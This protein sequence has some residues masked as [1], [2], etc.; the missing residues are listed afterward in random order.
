MQKLQLPSPA[1]IVHSKMTKCI[2]FFNTPT[3][4]NDVHRT[5]HANLMQIADSL[6]HDPNTC[7]SP[8]LVGLIHYVTECSSNYAHPQI[9]HIWLGTWNIITLSITKCQSV[10]PAL[11]CS[12]LTESLLE[13]LRSY[14]LSHNSALSMHLMER[15][16]LHPLQHQLHLS[17]VL[18]KRD[19][20]SSG[21]YHHPISR[22][23]PHRTSYLS[24]SRS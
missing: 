2:R 8:M 17:P 20:P 10:L 4:A 24:T 5:A 23:S 12:N 19:L 21:R 6:L 9:N 16:H 7:S 22:T 1:H 11:L 14:T 15:V 3:D 13:L 18:G